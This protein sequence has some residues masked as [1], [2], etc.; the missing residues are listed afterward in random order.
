[1]RRADLS[2]KLTK[3][4]KI[5]A[6]SKMGRLLHNPYKY[7][8]AILFKNLVYPLRKRERRELA[9]TFFGRK[10]HIDLPAA[11]DIYL[12]GGKSHSSEIRLARFIIQHLSE[13]DHFLDIGAHYGYFSLLASTIVGEDG[14]VHAFEP[15]SKSFELLRLNSVQER[16]II[17]HK[18]AVSDSKGT[19]VFYEFPNLFS[20]YN[21]SNIEQF[22]DQDWF[23]EFRPERVEVAAT[24]IDLITQSD[25]II[26]ALIKIDVEGAEYN[27]IKGGMNFLNS[28]AP[29]L[30]MECLHPDRHNEEHLKAFQLLTEELGYQAHI[31]LAS[32][33]IE[34]VGD[35]N[36]Y[37]IM[38]QLE[39]DNI[40][41]RKRPE[42]I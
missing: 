23:P 17:I 35:I 13:G 28:N 4:E 30:V 8:S 41:F 9:R 32:G 14:S 26:P 22:E 12:T 31:I 25:R 27:V 1:M 34:P 2:E 6:A 16:N 29:L 15:A 24:T 18:E 21:T 33:Y 7:I 40:V 37:L 38:Q 42:L 3:V 20:E 5:A 19:L 11:T 36:N 39:S 10:M